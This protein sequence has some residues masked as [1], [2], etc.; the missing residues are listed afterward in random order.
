M[1]G[2]FYGATPGIGKCGVECVGLA[3]ARGG[4]RAI[5]SAV[6]NI[7]VQL[8]AGSVWSS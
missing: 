3:E 7:R 8:S 5:V 6:M 1:G 2:N 4:W